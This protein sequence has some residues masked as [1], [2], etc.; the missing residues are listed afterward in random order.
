MKAS[1]SHASP[2]LIPV[3]RDLQQPCVVHML[4]LFVNIETNRDMTMIYNDDIGVE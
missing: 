1:P 2:D 3:F 4:C